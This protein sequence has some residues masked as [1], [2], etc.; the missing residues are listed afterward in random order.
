MLQT[1]RF[2]SAFIKAL[3]QTEQKTDKYLGDNT[4]VTECFCRHK[5]YILLSQILVLVDTER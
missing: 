1:R 3:K 2:F 4:F 5:L